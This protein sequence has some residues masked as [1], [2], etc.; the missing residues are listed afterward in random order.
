MK[1]HLLDLIG[2]AI[3]LL[4]AC[5]WPDK[6]S[7]FREKQEVLTVLDENDENFKIELCSIKKILAGMGSFSDLPL[8]P[9]KGSSVTRTEAR[10]TQWKLTEELGDAIQKLLASHQQ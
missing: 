8:Y 3:A 5:G 6:A 10:E 2:Q 7:W 1:R 9:K 4:D